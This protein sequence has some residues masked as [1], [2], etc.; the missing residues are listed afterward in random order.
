MIICQCH[1]VAKLFG[2]NLIFEHI[3]LEIHEGDRIG[4]VGRNG[5]G[6]TTLFQLLA[7]VEQPDQ[8]AVHL[9]KGAS[10]GYLAQIP[11]YPSGTTVRTVLETAFSATKALEQ[12]MKEIEK[13]MAAQDGKLA[14][15]L[16]E[17]GQLQDRFS[18][19]GGYEMESKLASISNGIGITTLLDQNFTSLSGG[20][21]TKVC[22][23]HMLLLNPALL[24]LDEPTNHLDI[25]AVE[26]LEAFLKEYKGTVVI[27]SHDRFFLDAIVTKIVDLEDGELHVYH[28]NYSVFVKEKQERLL[29]EF[30]E[31][32]EQQKKI[33][34]MKERIKQLREWANQ[35]DNPKLHR[36]AQNMER[37]LERM[38]K[39]K[40]PILERKAMNLHF[41][42]GERSG[43]DVVLM[44]N[45]SK[46][47]D[48]Q[49]LFQELTMHVQYQERVA[50]VGRNGSGKST[51]LQLLLGNE[52]PDTG[53]V[54]LGAG[55]KLG[56]LSQHLPGN[57]KASVID[58]FR[59]HVSVTEGE[60]RHILARFLFY[61]YDVFKRSDQLSG[62]ERMRLRLAQLMYQDVNVLLLDE[63]T[64][65]LDIESREVLE[66]ALED[67]TGTIIAVSHDRY[68]LN[69]LFPITYWIERQ[70]L[71][72][73]VG[74]YDWARQK[75]R[76]MP[77]P[78]EEKVAKRQPQ[79]PA[80]PKSS[81]TDAIEAELVA[82]EEAL[83]ALHEKM[84]TQEEWPELMKL[85]AEVDR[86]EQRQA[87]LYEQL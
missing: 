48:E 82:I 5:S 42:E 46:A 60:A 75:L 43:K 51:L 71:Y 36:K 22:L 26:W 64:N 62:G 50:I 65:H 35:G 86:Y 37:A 1:E 19:L 8:G 80:A 83:L 59:D 61:G 72:S 73:F 39:L 25:E 84:A 38:V 29:R 33:K 7:G 85:Q 31:Y 3:S 56:Y 32:E 52:Q 69:K 87:Q 78:I 66:E 58:T 21:Q 20:E 15:L 6:K 34:K 57:A 27:I 55:V 10:V 11:H 81:T 44:E 16:E 77:P 24:L 67:F 30:Q 74:A 76:E 53:S 13:Q 54:R 28:G 41:Q 47:F 14:L 63:P 17:Y 40:R 79:R 18:F 12:R 70:Q 23:A 45:V 4:I 9:K 2:G 68:F 49:L